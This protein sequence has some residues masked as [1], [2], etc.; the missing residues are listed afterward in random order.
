M[1]HGAGSDRREDGF[2]SGAVALMRRAG[3][4]TLRYDLRGHG[5]SEGKLEELTLAGMLNDLNI[6]VEHM[7]PDDPS[8]VHLIGASFSGGVTAFY[9]AKRGAASLSLIYP[10]LDYRRRYLLEKP[11]WDGSRIS[12]ACAAMLTE[13][14]WIDHLGVLKLGRCFLNEL[15]WIDPTLVAD[16]IS[17]PTIVFHGTEDTRVPAAASIKWVSDVAG[18]QLVLVNGAD[19]ELAEPGDGAHESERT[20][21][22]HAEVQQS[23]INW[24]LRAEENARK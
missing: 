22:W 16:D 11:Y 14:G 17:C 12:S 5:E 13:D 23:I 6:M 15:P 24:I 20:V 4:S 7:C 21:A 10:V 1:A 8:S 3:V 18:A 9:A 19:H 2:Y